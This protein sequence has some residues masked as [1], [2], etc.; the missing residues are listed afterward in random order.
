MS[1][2]ALIQPQRVD[3]RTSTNADWLDGLPLIAQAGAGGVVAGGGNVGNGALALASVAVGTALG[4]HLVAVTAVGG[5]TRLTVTDPSGEVTAQ[6]VVGLP[7][8]AA[9][10]TFTLAQGATPFAVED[11]FAISVLPTPIDLTGLR[12][13]L[14][15]RASATDPAIAMSASTADPV[16]TILAGTTGGNIAMRKLRASLARSVFQPGAYVYDLLASDPATGLAV[17]AF[18][19]TLEH[20]DGVT[21]LP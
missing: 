3:F 16:P 10:L 20:V 5:A 14:Q 4:A 11:T 8:Y 1:N 9:G 2:L 13:D 19:G 7:L 6:G 18:Y 15:A 12:F 21:F 17:P